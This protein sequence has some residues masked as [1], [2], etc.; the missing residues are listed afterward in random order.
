MTDPR[1]LLTDSRLDEIE[2]DAAHSRRLGLTVTFA[3]VNEQLA[4]VQELRRLRQ[5]LSDTRA[6]AE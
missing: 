3:V 2:R 4:F 5:E 6:E 1:L